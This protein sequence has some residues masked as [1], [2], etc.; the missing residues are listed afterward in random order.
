MKPLVTRLVRNVF[1]ASLLA[2]A[3]PA[4]HAQSYPT[5]PIKVIVPYPAGSGVD[6]VARATVSRMA[7]AL[8]QPIVIENKAGAGGN[9]GVELA[10]RAP[11][12][13]YTLLFDATQL[14]GNVGISKVRYDPIKDFEPIALVSRVSAI[15]VVPPESPAKTVQE[16][17]AM[18]KAKPGSLNY[19]SGGNGGIG[20]Y[21]GELLKSNGGDLDIVHV[22][23]K[24]AAEQ[25]TS[26]MTGQTQ[27][28][29]P[30][31]QIALPFIKAGKL[32]A[33]GVTGANRSGALPDVPTMQEAM[34]PG[35]A[36]DAWYGLLA[37][38]GTPQP[39]LDRLHAEL[40]KVL[41]DPAVR[42]TLTDSSQE[43][44]GSTPAEFAA[45]IAKDLKVWSDLAVK[46]NV[47]VD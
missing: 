8:G 42:K 34:K 5:G 6:G 41:A 33:L 23:Y 19:A 45:V 39:I 11:N 10:A 14:V 30:A 29:F 21:S 46:L 20:H 26:V 16:L 4:L 25:V 32:R 7:T 12:D 37:P 3:L 2:I 9:I 17:V 40:M 13:G 36:L 47:K 22:P 44:V 43:V 18:A 24:S 1:A 28:A 27:L 38:A 31:L 35:F 15:L